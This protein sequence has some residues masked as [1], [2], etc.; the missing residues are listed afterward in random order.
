M[1]PTVNLSNA[2]QFSHIYS[3]MFTSLEIV[4]RRPDHAWLNGEHS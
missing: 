3:H 4:N 1:I 2:K